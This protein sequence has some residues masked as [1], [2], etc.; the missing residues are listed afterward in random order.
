[1]RR[2]DGYQDPFR[3]KRR[4]RSW[5]ATI[6]GIKIETYKEKEE[7]KIQRKQKTRSLNRKGREFFKLM[8]AFVTSQEGNDTSPGPVS[9]TT[10]IRSSCRIKHSSP[11]CLASYCYFYLNR[12]SPPL[13]YL[14]NNHD[15]SHNN[16]GTS[17][18]T[19]TLDDKRHK[20]K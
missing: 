13:L 4:K 16:A 3:V 1:M 18:T 19:D 10:T 8:D 17:P 14:Q 12:L 20:R 7:E 2:T 5:T 6:D 11:N 15:S 9:A